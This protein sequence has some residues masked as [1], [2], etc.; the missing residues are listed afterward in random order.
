MHIRVSGNQKTG[1]QE[2]VVN[3]IKVIVILREMFQQS[4][5][6]GNVLYVTE[7]K[8]NNKMKD[9]MNRQSFRKHDR[10]KK[11]RTHWIINYVYSLISLSANLKSP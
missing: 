8:R 3:S 9:E 2:D 1:L 10:P 11:E 6:Q 4:S 5:W 7:E